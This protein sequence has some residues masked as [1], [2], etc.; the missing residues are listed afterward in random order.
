MASCRVLGL[1]M[2]LISTS[3]C[4]RMEWMRQVY[5]CPFL[6]VRGLRLLESF[7]SEWGYKTGIRMAVH[8]ASDKAGMLF[9]LQEPHGQERLATFQC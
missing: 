8:V 3:E 6:A 7:R 5:Y 2:V 1:L 4:T 9:V